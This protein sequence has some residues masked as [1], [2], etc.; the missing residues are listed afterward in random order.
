MKRSAFV[1]IGV[2]AGISLSAQSLT[3]EVVAT[4]GTSFSGAGTTLDFSIGEVATSTLTAGVHT[5]TQ[6]FH[7]PEIHF[8]SLENYNGDFALTLYPNPTEQFVTVETTKEDLL[9]IQ[10]Y[11]AN[12]KILMVSPVFSQKTSIDLLTWAA[13]S[14]VMVVSTKAGVPVHSY[15]VIKKSGN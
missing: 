2:L 13:G 5:L 8:A 10:V 6:G 12:G 4:S 9:K 14:Y 1:T 11:D 7:Q 3:S 15:T